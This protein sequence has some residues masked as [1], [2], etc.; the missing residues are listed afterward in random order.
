MILHPTGREKQVELNDDRSHGNV[1]DL[2]IKL[3]RVK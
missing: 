3:E 2:E 1:A